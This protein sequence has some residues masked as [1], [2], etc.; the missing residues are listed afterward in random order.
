MRMVIGMTRTDTLLDMSRSC[1]L[2]IN[3]FWIKGRIRLAEREWKEM[4]G[5]LC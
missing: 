1:L 2:W 5:L 3:S 4:W